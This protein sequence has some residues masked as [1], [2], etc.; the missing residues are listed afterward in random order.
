MIFLEQI[1]RSFLQFCLQTIYPAGLEHGWWW[2]DDS[3]K[4][5]EESVVGENNPEQQNTEERKEKVIT[6]EQQRI[7]DLEKKLVGLRAEIKY[8]SKNQEILSKNLENDIPSEEDKNS[9]EL[10]DLQF[11][12]DSLVKQ[13]LELKEQE[14]I[15][16]E[17]CNRN[18]MPKH[19]LSENVKETLEKMDTLS[20]SEFLKLNINDRLALVTYNNIH[21]EKVLEGT[22]KHLEINFK[23][24]GKYNREVYDKTTAGTILHERIREIEIKWVL[25]KRRENGIRG[26]FYSATWE[27]GLVHDHTK[28]EVKQVV[29]AAEVLKIKNESDKQLAG[30]KEYDLWTK[31]YAIAK[32]AL[33]RGIEPKFAVALL[34]SRSDIIEKSDEGGML[35]NEDLFI[36]IDR[37]MGFFHR[38]FWVEYNEKWEKNTV[39]EWV[40]K[41]ER[42]T[43]EFLAYVSWAMNPKWFEK[44]VIASWYQWAELTEA[45][46][47][48]NDFLTNK[49]NLTYVWSLK[50]E[51]IAERSNITVAEVERIRS[52]K[53]FPPNSTDAKL[54][55]KIAAQSANIDI[56]WSENKKIHEIMGKESWGG[57]VGILN[58]TVKWMSGSEFKRRALASKKDNPIGSYSTAS[59][60]GQLLLCNVDLYY[61]SWRH[62]IW[63]PIDEAIWFLKYVKDR[64]GTPDEAS[65]IYGVTGYY[66]VRGQ[67]KYK[68]FKEWY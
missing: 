13:I 42:Y 14:V 57:Q 54:L 21:G 18:T 24:N 38:E 41:K 66:T 6:P 39:R 50:S 9:K 62:G 27:R 37:Q 29:S 16:E 43:I 36:E 52:L 63:D 30:L 1:R 17:R 67:Q 64:Y 11:Q 46:K 34:S 44:C 10:R 51:K 22:E 55:L 48:W 35:I 28:I 23:F 5:V 59:W 65:R 25:Y 53:R 2:Q 8:K 40:G 20:F 26:E 56:S 58:Y 19:P 32:E 68:S 4:Q 49:T 15:L 47:A 31:E 12:V 33:N 60:L 61:P 7:I 45:L 3:A